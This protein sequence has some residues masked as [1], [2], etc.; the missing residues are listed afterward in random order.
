LITFDDGYSDIYEIVYPMTVEFGFPAVVFAV[1][2]WFDPYPRPETNRGHFTTSEARELL[3][4]GLWHIGGHSYDGH[5][6][7]WGANQRAGAFLVTREYKEW[8]RR[9]ETLEEYQARVWQDITLNTNALKLAGVE[10]PRDFA[11]PYGD[12]SDELIK[13]LNEAGYRYLFTNERGL[14]RPNQDPSRIPRLDAGVNAEATIRL[15][16][17]SFSQMEAYDRIAGEVIYRNALPLE[18]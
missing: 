11:F 2:K 9:T 4:S 7:V 8:E 5:H 10:Q 14:C 15:L 17:N 3:D 12:F 18:E 13:L 1:T 16:R 6:L